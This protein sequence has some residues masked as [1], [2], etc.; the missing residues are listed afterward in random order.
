M[1]TIVIFGSLLLLAACASTKQPSASADAQ[2]VPSAQEA[3]KLGFTAQESDFTPLLTRPSLGGVGPVLQ[4]QSNFYFAGDLQIT[5]GKPQFY[6]CMAGTNIPIATGKGV[7]SELASL[8]AAKATHPG[9]ILKA[10][11]HG[12]FIGQETPDYP[13][14]L[15]VTYVN[16]LAKGIVCTQSQSLPGQWTASLPGTTAG[17]AELTIT[18]TF[19]FTCKLNVGG[20]S[21]AITGSWMMTTG[22]QIELFY[23]T[24]SPYL[25]HNLAFN[26]EKGTLFVPTDKGVLTFSRK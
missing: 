20:Q 13:H 10:Q 5:D 18:P 21:S 9:E 12:Y 7:Y 8:Y 25:G 2:I 1:R 4:S 11:L 15:V 23:L 14:T 24:D 19:E 22:S 3:Q 17:T 26:P 6:D 16:S